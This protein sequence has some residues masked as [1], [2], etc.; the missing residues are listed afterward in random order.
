MN[1][2][3]IARILRPLSPIFRG[4]YSCNDLPVDGRG[5]MV[6]NTDPRGKPG[7]HWIAIYIEDGLGEYFDSFGRRPTEEFERYLNQHCKQWTFNDKQLQSIASRFC[8]YYCV[9]YCVLRCRGFSLRR[10]VASL[11]NDTGFNDVIVH[12]FFCL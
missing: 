3:Q 10:I 5:L 8:G 2:E 4:V 12:G 7:S 9:Y 1:S 11:S 6:C